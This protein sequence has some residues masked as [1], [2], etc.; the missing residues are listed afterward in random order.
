MGRSRSY[1]ENAVL[2]GAMHAFRRKGYQAISIR[3]LENATG[4]K[5]GSIYN[6]FGDKAGLFDAAFTHY[7][8]V[9]L[10]RRIERYA[11]P[12]AGLR[13]LRALFVSL[14]H[15]PRGE[16]HGCLITNCAV[17]FGSADSPRGVSE[18][19]RI[20]STVFAER[21]AAARR[22]G[23][24]R[25]AIDPAAAALKLLALYQGILVLVRAGHEKAALKRLIT[26]E[27]DDL[28]NSHDT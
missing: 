14:L 23:A 21:L 18:G 17:E 19:L 13:G 20:L 5:M 4:L 7:N 3:D 10:G 25:D 12:K 2:A 6:S 26:D 16:S 27:F 11:P 1:D 15:E 22:S 9:V 24:L 28:E 8:Q